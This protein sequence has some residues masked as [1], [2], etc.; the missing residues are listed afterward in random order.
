MIPTSKRW[1][2]PLAL[3]AAALVAAVIG[4]A[5]QTLGEPER[6]SAT[7]ILGAGRGTTTL[8]LVVSRWSSGAE[9]DR[10]VSTL[11][12]EGQDKLLDVIKDAPK[13]GYI[14]T[15]TSLGWDLRFTQHAALPDGGERLL[16]ITDRPIGFYEE[17]NQLRTL[18]YPFSVVTLNVDGDGHGTGTLAVAARLAADKNSKSV[19][20]ENIGYQPI[21]LENVK[22]EKND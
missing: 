10:L 22:R 12:D 11:A 4:V 3:A 9:L 5:A 6:F 2:L 17:A 18:D 20:V 19:V 21:Q 7:A 1:A 8:E 13:A 15:P 14:R 16:V